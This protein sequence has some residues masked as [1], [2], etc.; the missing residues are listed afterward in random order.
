MDVERID[1][2]QQR[3]RQ[4]VLAAARTVLRRDGVQGATMEAVAAESGVARSTLYRNW[5]S[6]E[7][8]LD[9]AIDQVTGTAPPDD[10][11]APLERLEAVVQGLATNLQASEWGDTLPSIVAAIDASSEFAERYRGFVDSRRSDVRRIIGDAV[12]AGALPGHVDADDLIDDLVGPLFYRR[13]IR[14]VP[15]SPAW[16]TAHIDRILRAHAA[17]P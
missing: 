6:R 8:L 10:D 1:P 5:D 11:G 4:A 13:L 7:A 2:R 9:D 14:R 3:T 17:T 16:T 15:T 12:R